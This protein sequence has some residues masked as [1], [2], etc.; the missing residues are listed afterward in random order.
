M[1]IKLWVGGFELTIVD[2]DHYKAC[3]INWLNR[4]EKEGGYHSHIIFDE[5]LNMDLAM[6]IDMPSY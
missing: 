1:R 3:W 4:N 5:C 6:C 2:K